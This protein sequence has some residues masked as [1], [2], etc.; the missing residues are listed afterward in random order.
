[1]SKSEDQT[2]ESSVENVE[3]G[4]SGAVEAGPE[5][6]QGAAEVPQESKDGPPTDGNSPQ[7]NSSE[8]ADPPESGSS[9]DE[10]GDDTTD[11]TVAESE[12]VTVE[13]LQK[14]L[15]DASVQVTK[16]KDLALRAEAE[17]Q[18]VRRRASKDLENAHKYGLDKLVQNLLPVID[19][20]EK[21]VESADSSED[22]SQSIAEG[23]A[24]CLKMLLDVLS[25]D[26]VEV[27]DPLGEPF[28]PN[29]HQAVS[30]VENPDAEP[31][32]VVTVIQKGYT[33]NKRLVRPAMVM[34]SKS[35]P[36]IDETA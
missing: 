34:V 5:S 6:G 31:N 20:L 35:A 24:L 7:E 22:E 14:D 30:M 4:A 9:V 10:A 15:D 12:S 8:S 29:V 1:M 32:S 11:E 13:S 28:D 21:A 23:V 27:V 19:A 25:R 17:M 18:N 26:G 33:L 3:T 2:E 36:K 16:F